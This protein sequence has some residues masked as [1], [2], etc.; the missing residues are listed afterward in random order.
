[1]RETTVPWNYID[2]IIDDRVSVVSD[3][4]IGPGEFA[5]KDEAAAAFHRD[6][7]HLYKKYRDTS[8][9][10]NL[11]NLRNA[12]AKRKGNVTRSNNVILAVYEH[13]HGQ[14]ELYGVMMSM[15]VNR[16]ARVNRLPLLGG[17]VS[18]WAIGELL[19]RYPEIKNLCDKLEMRY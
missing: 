15:L 16:L 10:G 2:I 11:K 5:T 13:P 8:Y 1:M 12:W 18:F 9:A 7:N 6:L 4:K 3:H 17:H 14:A 19:K